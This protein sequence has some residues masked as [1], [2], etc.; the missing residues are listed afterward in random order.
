[1]NFVS[2]KWFATWWRNIKTHRSQKRILG[3]IQK[4]QFL[5]E[6]R[7]QITQ[8]S[9][10]TFYLIPLISYNYYY[11]N[12]N[13]RTKARII[14]TKQWAWKLGV[15]LE[16]VVANGGYDGFS[17]MNIL[18]SNYCKVRYYRLRVESELSQCRLVLI[19]KLIMWMNRLWLV[20]LS[21]RITDN[22][23]LSFSTTN[24][25]PWRSRWHCHRRS[26]TKRSLRQK[27]PRVG[28]NRPDWF[29]AEPGFLHRTWISGS[30]KR[31]TRILHSKE[32]YNTRGTQI[33]P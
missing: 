25:K 8:I 23:T 2:K 3:L 19:H 10:T 11:S 13:L 22:T 7:I 1:M 33:M 24:S 30:I 12:K 32:L 4:T 6:P 14:T 31:S 20:S 27:L 5:I 18:S 9:T 16:D 28:I 26:R 29:L 17:S 21:A 15:H